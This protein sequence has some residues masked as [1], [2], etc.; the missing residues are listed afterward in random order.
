MSEREEQAA[1]YMQAH[2]L[3]VWCG[4]REFAGSPDWASLREV[5]QIIER[6]L[7]RLYIEMQKEAG[8]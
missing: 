1:K 8:E 3:V 6:Q 2:E 7:G 5:L 4:K